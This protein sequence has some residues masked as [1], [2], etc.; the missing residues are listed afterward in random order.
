MS[1]EDKILGRIAEFARHLKTHEAMPKQRG[2]PK[3]EKALHDWSYGMERARRKALA[4][5]LVPGAGA[6]AD[7]LANEN[8]RNAYNAAL[9][10]LPQK[11]PRGTQHADLLYLL[12]RHAASLSAGAV[13]VAWRTVC[14]SRSRSYFTYSW[15][16]ADADQPLVLVL[17][18]AGMHTGFRTQK[19]QQMHARYR[20]LNTACGLQKLASQIEVG[21]LPAS[22][23]CIGLKTLPVN[24]CRRGSWLSRVD[25]RR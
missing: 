9:R 21:V 11:S 7:H 8:I 6:H 1:K 24:S 16:A 2:C 17:S 14:Y 5:T 3:E 18:L 25:V 10:F 13:E 20:N 22:Q 19:P 15:A 23:G 12:E 4:G